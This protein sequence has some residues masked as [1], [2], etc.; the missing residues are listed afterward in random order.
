MGGAK[1]GFSIEVG[2]SGFV[3]GGGAMVAAG[4]AWGRY[5]GWGR[6]L[7]C[8]IKIILNVIFA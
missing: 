1:P 5:G 7:S 2:G 4:A 8:E 6:G 3:T